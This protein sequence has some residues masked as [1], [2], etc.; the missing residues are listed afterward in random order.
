MP[1]LL[2]T[3]APETLPVTDALCRWAADAVPGLSLDHERDK[4]LCYARAR[5]LTNVDWSEAL[6]LWWLE[7]HARAVRRGQLQLPTALGP[8]PVPEPPPLYD[9]ELHAQMQ[10]D[11]ARLC[12][13]V[14]TSMLGMNDSAGVGRRCAQSSLTVEDMAR[15]RDPA[16]LAQMRA[17]KATL[18]AQAML[19]QAQETAL[20]TAGAAD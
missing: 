6:K 3:P 5:S 17:R 10:A 12:G 19:L 20:E 11:I 8:T 2:E 18:Q 4:F 7:A 14:G 15:E 1:R 9:A 13:R 16:Y